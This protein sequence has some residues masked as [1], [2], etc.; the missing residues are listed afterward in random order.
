[1]P[2]IPHA[3]SSYDKLLLGGGWGGTGAD[4]EGKSW[5]VNYESLHRE[6]KHATDLN[7]DSLQLKLQF[8]YFG[9]QLLYQEIPVKT[10]THVHH[11]SH[12]CIMKVNLFTGCLL[13]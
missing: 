11:E 4:A 10:H 5:Q 12:M 7:F 1:M 3:G 8:L 13:I 6:K 9:S 2:L